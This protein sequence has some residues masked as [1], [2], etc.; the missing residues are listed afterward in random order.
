M[1]LLSMLTLTENP[2]TARVQLW[3]EASLS[4]QELNG[5]VDTFS[6]YGFDDF[7][8]AFEVERN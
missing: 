7:D 1:E 2:A 8:I 4:F 5:V 6:H 3:P